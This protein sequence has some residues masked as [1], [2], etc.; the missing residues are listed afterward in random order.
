MVLL[1]LMVPPESPPPIVTFDQWSESKVLPVTH[2]QSSVCLRRHC[3]QASLRMLCHSPIKIH[4]DVT[5]LS[6][7]WR[8]YL[9]MGIFWFI[10]LF[11]FPQMGTT[12]LEFAAHLPQGLRA[13]KMSV[14]LIG[15]K[16]CHASINTTP[17]NIEELGNNN[18]HRDNARVFHC[19]FLKALPWINNIPASIRCAVQGILEVSFWQEKLNDMYFK[20]LMIT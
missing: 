17:Q 2:E 20:L 5:L 7:V 3:W 19:P 14:V 4:H 1:R 12:H 11:S 13:V 9:S 8:Q 16:K 6:V 18:G 10:Y 15:W